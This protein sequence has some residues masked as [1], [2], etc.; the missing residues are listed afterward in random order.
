VFEELPPPVAFIRLLEE[1][2]AVATP[3]ASSVK[4]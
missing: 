3:A 4:A 1:G 2:R